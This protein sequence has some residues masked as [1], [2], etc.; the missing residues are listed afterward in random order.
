MSI[1]ALRLKVKQPSAHYRNPKLFQNEY[2]STLSLPTRTTIMG[3]ITY[4]CDRRLKSDINKECSI[5]IGVIGTYKGKTLEFSR[6]EK[7][8]FWEGYRKLKKG[9]EAIKILRTG[10]YYDYYKNFKVENSVLNYEVLK[11]VEMSIFF[12]CDDNEEF[13]FVKKSLEN[14]CRYM[15]LGRKEDFVVPYYKGI[16]VEEVNLEEYTAESTREAIK[17]G[18]KL[19][20]T[21]IRVDLRNELSYESI[22]NEGTLIALPRKY[23]DLEKS[24]D[25]RVLEFSHYIYIGHEGIYP[26]NVKV[27]IYNG[28][29]VREVFTW[30]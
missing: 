12:S 29:N 4:L 24:K 20:N 8:E 11:D 7:I 18:L 17:K 14:P 30:L 19:K 25:K 10:E 16:F 1:R 13:E 15:N 22:I 9:K 26:R 23:K 3:M 6:G 2:I 28:E 5:N 27:N 21:Y